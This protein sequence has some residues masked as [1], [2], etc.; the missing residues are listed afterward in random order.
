[1]QI[2]HELLKLLKL[3]SIVFL[4]WTAIYAVLVL[5]HESIPQEVQGIYLTIMAFY[6]GM[7]EQKGGHDE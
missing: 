3:R 1:M 4:L 5:T 7:S 2:F 6:F